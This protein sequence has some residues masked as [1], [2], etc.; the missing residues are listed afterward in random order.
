MLTFHYYLKMENNIYS[1]KYEINSLKDHFRRFADDYIN[2]TEKDMNKNKNKIEKDLE[3]T[4]NMGSRDYVFIPFCICLISRYSYIDEIKRCL[5]SIFYLLINK[6]NVKNKLLL[7]HLIM[8]LIDSVP[9]PQIGTV[10]QFYIPYNKNNE[11]KLKYPK[12]NDIQIINMKISFL[13]KYF[14]I[15]LILTT[16]RLILFE[17]KKYYL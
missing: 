13:L 9:I 16:I 7:N 17:K 14:S 4:Q 5:K 15:D 11:I 12:L 3:Q 10:I 2:M 1:N 6:K 8:H